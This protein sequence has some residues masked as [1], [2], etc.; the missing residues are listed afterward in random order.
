M[1]AFILPQISWHL[2][3]VAPRRNA[4]T[5]NSHPR[6]CHPSTVRLCA[7][8]E[9]SKRAI[10]VGAGLAGLAAAKRLADEG[11]SV[12]VLEASDAV[13]GRVRS[14]LVDGF[15]LDRGFQVFICAYPEL[16]SVLNYEALKLCEFR[17]GAV[18]RSGGAFYGLTD[19]FR[20]PLEALQ[21][22]FSPVGT[23]FDKLRVASLRLLL[24]SHQPDEILR[25]GA[26]TA[27][28]STEEYLR[29]HFSESIIDQFFRPF[30]QGIFLAPLAEQSARM[31]AFVF[32]MFSTDPAALPANG[33]GSVAEQLAASLPSNL[34][35]IELNSPVTDLGALDAP[36]KI[37][38]TDETVAVRL[39]TAFGYGSLAEPQALGSIC[40][41]FASTRPPPIS[42]PVLILN[43]DGPGSSRDGGLV[44]NMFFPTNVAPSY[45]PP[46]KTL[47]STTIVGNGGGMSDDELEAAVRSQ[48]SHW[49]GESEVSEWKFLRAYRVGYS[50]PRQHPESEFD[51][52][53]KSMASPGLF[54]CGDY[55]NTPTVNGALVSGRLAAE[56]A[57]AYMKQRV[58]PTID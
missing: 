5:N 49:F 19:P 33:I 8:A 40:L 45:G 24:T 32:R 37:V 10:V 34:V 12:R 29:A 17:P 48:M 55:R 46:G 21:G 41:Y 4:A 15:I 7:G 52:P 58:P 6:R 30:Y 25:G 54:L 43:G 31:F 56:E 13:G 57:L 23:I 39:L 36:V 47:V 50:Q 38:A 14:D 35:T 27:T 42:R 9:H 44:N 26:G 20:A 51:R 16:K 53:P 2:K 3:L 18:V 28:K 1:I 11:V 22:L